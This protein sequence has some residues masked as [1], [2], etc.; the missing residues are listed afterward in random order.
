VLASLPTG[1][2]Y[3]IVTEDGASIYRSLN[4]KTFMYVLKLLMKSVTVPP[5]VVFFR[6]GYD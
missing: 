2:Q 1:V 4:W 5:Y 3:T 6:G